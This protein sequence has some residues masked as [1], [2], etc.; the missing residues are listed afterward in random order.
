MRHFFFYAAL[1]ALA[2]PAL[3]QDAQAGRETF[4]RYCAVC[5][6]IEATGQGPMQSV[7]LVAPANLT[8]LTAQNGGVFPLLRVV[9][10]IDGRDPLVSHGSEMPIY[11]DFFEGSDVALKTEAGQPILTSRPVA[12]LVAYLQE[13][14]DRS[15]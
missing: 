14:Q 11:G 9:K 5:H 2:A 1:L 8:R 7:L 3:G 10:R 6:G 13:L 4:Q 15:D 12:D